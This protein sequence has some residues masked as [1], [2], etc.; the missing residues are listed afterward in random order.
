MA[1]NKNPGC[2]RGGGKSTSE[3]NASLAL[4]V[5]DTMPDPAGQPR[6]F[7]LAELIELS[8][9]LDPFTAGADTLAAFVEEANRLA[10]AEEARE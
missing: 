6:K 5:Y 7:T 10:L 2:N 1:E 4:T 3:G 9:I 8:A